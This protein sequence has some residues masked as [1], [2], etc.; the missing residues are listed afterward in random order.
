MC[1]RFL[2]A[3]IVSML[4]LLTF[5]LRV[6]HTLNAQGKTLCRR[7]PRIL[8]ATTLSL[9]ACKHL[10]AHAPKARHLLCCSRRPAILSISR[11][12]CATCCSATCCELRSRCCSL[13]IFFQPRKHFLHNSVSMR[14]RNLNPL[15]SK[16][17]AF[18]RR[19]I[20]STHVSNP[21]SSICLRH[22]NTT[23][24]AMRQRLRES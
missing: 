11:S 13:L 15:R 12:R 24:R 4:N 22:C 2:T 6:T 16:C 18:R 21:R 10:A 19:T 3:L 20:V 7:M 8:F 14:Q 1:H 23:L 9:F 5:E 17:A